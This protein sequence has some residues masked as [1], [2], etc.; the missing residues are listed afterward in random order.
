MYAKKLFYSINSIKDLDLCN[1]RLEYDLR[2]NE[3]NIF[4]FPTILIL[5]AIFEDKK[6]N[7]KFRLL[8]WT[9]FLSTNN[10]SAGNKIEIIIENLS[11]VTLDENIKSDILSTSLIPKVQKEAKQN[12]NLSSS[13]KANQFCIYCLKN[14]RRVIKYNLKYKPHFKFTPSLII[15]R[16]QGK[17]HP[18]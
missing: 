4:K 17:I 6:L 14:G 11:L 15:A 3:K 13:G 16:L 2:I 10:L 12:S 18:K 1:V 9:E 7:Y 8:V 5:N